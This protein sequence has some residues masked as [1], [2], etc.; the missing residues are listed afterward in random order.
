MAV[1]VVV[2][3][4]GYQQFVNNLSNFLDVILVLFIPWSAVNLADYFLVRHGSY[5]VASFFT[6]S[7]EYGKCAWRG[8][9]AYFTGLGAEWLFVKQ[10]DYTGVLVRQL[11]GAD[12]S[13]LVGW[14]VAAGLYLFLASGARQ[15]P[16]GRPAASGIGLS[17]RYR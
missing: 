9:A 15:L 7:G 6:P 2:A 1:G 11:G 17:R 4:F 14:L 3:C 13:W 16:W 8:L 5:D 10:P 12:I